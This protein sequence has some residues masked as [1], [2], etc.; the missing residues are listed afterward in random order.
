MKTKGLE[1][2]CMLISVSDGRMRGGL[3][4]FNRL[5]GHSLLL[6]WL[7][8]VVNCVRVASY[9]VIFITPARIVYMLP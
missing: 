5:D 3:L 2:I 7:L 1:D 6:I 8:V 4:R 9:G